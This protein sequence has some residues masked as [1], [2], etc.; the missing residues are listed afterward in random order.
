MNIVMAIIITMNQYLFRKKEIFCKN[1]TIFLQLQNYMPTFI[2]KLLI[3]SI[4]I[5]YILCSYVVFKLKNVVF[6][7][8]M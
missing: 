1:P 7:A 6:G 2:V 4:I 8:K 5:L 3:N